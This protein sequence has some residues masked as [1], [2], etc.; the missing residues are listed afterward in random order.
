MPTLIQSSKKKKVVEKERA[1][2]Q[3]MENVGTRPVKT[4]N[5]EYFSL[6][7]SESEEFSKGC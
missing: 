5:L 4:R 3:T 2:R 6:C 1:S 7:K